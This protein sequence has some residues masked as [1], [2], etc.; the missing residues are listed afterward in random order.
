M[1]VQPTP[2][3]CEVAI[4]PASATMGSGGGTGTVSVKTQPECAWSAS[5]DVS[6]IS[7]VTPTS[8]QGT[9][10]V[11]FQVTVNTGAV[12]TGTFTVA[13]Q[14]IS[15]TQ[16]NG[17][18]FSVL[19]TSLTV[20]SG[21][22]SASISVTSGTGCAWTSSSQ[23]PWMTVTSGASV[24]GNGTAGF[25]VAQNLGV[26]RSGTVTVADR[27]ISV[28]QS[29]GCTFTI[30]PMSQTFGVS[31]GNGVVDVTTTAGCPWQATSQV[32]WITIRSGESGTGNGSVV[33]TVGPLILGKRSGS[34]TIAG[35]TFTV[36]QPN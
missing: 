12:R 2:V 17:C 16:S 31:G 18:T 7:K 11:E 27:T 25:S 14:K 5:A 13:D 23:V 24:T 21:N 22:G 19:P 3:K 28:T 34:L 1:S 26:Q 8:G 20:G 36:S 4:S 33:Y 15:V 10:Q 9:G 29:S 32:T 35:R 30:S 6:W